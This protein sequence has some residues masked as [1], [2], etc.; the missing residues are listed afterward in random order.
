MSPFGPKS[1]HGMR[2]VCKPWPG[3]RMLAHGPSGIH[4]YNPD[5][6]GAG[7]NSWGR[8]GSGSTHPGDWYGTER[9]SKLHT[10]VSVLERD[11]WFYL[12]GVRAGPR[13]EY[14]FSAVF[15]QV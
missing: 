14:G 7:P 1:S 2:P 5:L 15:S 12:L 10:K 4:N 3:Q 11:T 8:R 6:R 13:V 9:S